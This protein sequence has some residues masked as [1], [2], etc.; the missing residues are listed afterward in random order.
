MNIKKA[1]IEQLYKNILNRD[2]DASGLTHYLN[3]DFSLTEI[4]HQLRNSDEYKKNFL[5]YLVDEQNP[6]LGG[7]FIG[8]DRASYS[9]SVWKFI[10]EKYNIKTSLDV[11]SGRGFSSKYL[12]SLGVNT[13][14]IDGLKNNIEH[15]LVPTL[16]VDLT[17]TNFIKPVDFVNCVEVVEH[18]EE[19]YIN[20]LM[21]TLCNGNYVLITHAFPGQDG[22]HH[23]NCQPS[24][25]WIE[26]FIIKG[27]VFDKSESL[28][29]RG[30]ANNDGAAHISRSALFF[31]KHSE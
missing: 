23:V 9:Q 2:A 12:Q 11:G 28:F 16:E 25:Y 27:Y 5:T 21:D 18:I 10:V 26:K 1:K 15:A 19:K 17:K 8:N 13:T 24:E 29:L 3:S 31:I 6:H 22:W 14:A 20:N 7:N 4:E 30:L